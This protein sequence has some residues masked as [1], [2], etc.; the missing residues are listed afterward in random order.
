MPQKRKIKFILCVNCYLYAASLFGSSSGSTLL[1]NTL[2]AKPTIAATT[3]TNTN[4]GLGGLD[5]SV[6]NKG[7][8]QGNSSSTA[9]KENLLPNELMQTIDKFK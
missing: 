4:K 9:A 7:L 6:N 3:T 2:S 8:S 1:S 5:V